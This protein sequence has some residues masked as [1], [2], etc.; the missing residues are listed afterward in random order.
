MKKTVLALLALTFFVVLV[1]ISVVPNTVD[2][3]SGSQQASLF[4]KDGVTEASLRKIY[5]TSGKQNSR[6]R[7][8]WDSEK[9]LKVLIVPGHDDES[10]GAQFNHVREADLTVELGEELYRLLQQDSSLNVSLL[11]TKDGYDPE[12]YSYYENNR[13]EIFKFID[14]HKEIM[15]GLL[16]SGDYEPIVNIYHNTVPTDVALKLYGINKW[17]NEN[18]VDIVLHIHFNDYPRKVRNVEGKYSGFAIYVPESQYSNSVGS[19]AL[20]E[21]IRKRMDAFYPQSNLPTESGGVL[22]DQELIAIGSHNTL[23]GA[24]VLIEYSYIYE[25]QFTDPSTRA[26]MMSDLALQTYLG[27]QDFFGNKTDEGGPYGSRLLPYQWNTDLDKISTIN[28]DVLSLQAALA[29]EGL[30]PPPGNSKND[31]PISG[32][33]GSCTQKSVALF[34]EKYGLQPALGF[35]GELTRSKL[36]ELYGK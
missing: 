31:C 33:F 21:S 16:S 9:K 13:S 25:P 35:V 20:A 22:E 7:T 32:F 23:D 19:K 6:Q 12:F 10:S 17:A 3:Q 5:A 18:G 8:A 15:N 27:V 14:A 1:S 24:G 26:V 28:P 36:N 30:Y 11:R 2:Q 34:Q 4:S 29:Q